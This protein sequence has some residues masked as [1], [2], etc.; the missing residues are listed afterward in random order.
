[1]NVKKTLWVLV[2]MTLC[3]AAA[4]SAQGWGMGWGMMPGFDRTGGWSPPLVEKMTLKGNLVASEG[5]IA[6]K[7]DGATYYIRGIQGLIGFVDG[8]KEGA[9]VEIEGGVQKWPNSPQGTETVN[10]LYA[11]KLTIGGK[12]YD[13]LNQG[14]LSMAGSPPVFGR[15]RHHFR[16]F[17]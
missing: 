15:D 6:L 17:R 13:K 7:A 5:R 4:V 9:S 8:L 14:G 11:E 1:M 2:V 3:S 10:L 16:R 12:V